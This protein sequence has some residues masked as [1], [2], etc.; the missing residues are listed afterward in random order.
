MID[1]LKLTLSGT[2]LRT[3]LESRVQRHEELASR[4]TCET[5]RDKSDETEDAPLLPLHIC[6]NEA[7]RHTWRALTLAFVRDHVEPDETYRL[8]AADL[9]YGELLPEK[10]KWV[11]QDEYEERTRVGFGLERLV[12][13]VDRLVSLTYALR[14]RADFSRDE[15]GALETVVD[16]TAEFR[17]TRM[18]VGDGPEI[19]K[20]ERT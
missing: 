10:P 15:G 19:I 14:R 1:G 5:L 7:E 8:S 4:W 3:L 18:D 20:I 9:E 11:E 6:E 2:E 16:D 12:K 13:S 17:T